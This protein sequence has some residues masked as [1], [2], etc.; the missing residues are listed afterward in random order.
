M[1]CQLK[2][3]RDKVQKFRFIHKIFR[4]VSAQEVCLHMYRHKTIAFTWV[5]NCVILHQNQFILPNAES[6]NELTFEGKNNFLCLHRKLWI[7]L[8]Q[9]YYDFLFIMSLT[10]P[11]RLPPCGWWEANQQTQSSC[12]ICCLNSEE[13]FSSGLFS[14]FSAFS[15]PCSEVWPNLCVGLLHIVL[16]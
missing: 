6:Q 8:S 13:L 9:K 5:L 16:E 4:I 2:R 15:F 3:N 7:S 11:L 12:V 14:W 1:I 10:K